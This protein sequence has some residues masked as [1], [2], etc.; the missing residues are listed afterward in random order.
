MSIKLL[1]TLSSELLFLFLS[2]AAPHPLPREAAGIHALRKIVVHRGLTKRRQSVLRNMRIAK[3]ANAKIASNA[4]T[5]VTDGEKKS[6]DTEA[7]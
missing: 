1:S 4:I 3:Y 6:F 2:F 5:D 7:D